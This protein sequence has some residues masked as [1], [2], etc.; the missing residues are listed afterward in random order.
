MKTVEFPERRLEDDLISFLLDAWE[1]SDRV[2]DNLLQILQD[3]ADWEAKLK[4][5]GE[6]RPDIPPDKFSHLRKVV[7]EVLAERLPYSRFEE[8]AAEIRMVR[9]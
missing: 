5:L 7:R 8:V 6:K 9:K 3:Q 1:H 2:V 4:E